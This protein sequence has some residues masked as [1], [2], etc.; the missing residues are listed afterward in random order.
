MRLY[1]CWWIHGTQ[2]DGPRS[3]N[4]VAYD[5]VAEYL[6]RLAVTVTPPPPPPRTA[7]DSPSPPRILTTAEDTGAPVHRIVQLWLSCTDRSSVET[8]VGTPGCLVIVA[9]SFSAAPRRVSIPPP[10]ASWEFF[11]II[12]H[13]VKGRR[14]KSDIEQ[15]EKEKM[16]DV[17]TNLRDCLPKKWST[18]R[19]V[20]WG[21]GENYTGLII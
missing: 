21:A 11:L 19:S 18:S 6:I 13:Y 2:H 3:V 7:A 14:K 15:R 20:D 12:A 16:C 9:E 1:V 5:R 4:G 10:S 8:V 17:M